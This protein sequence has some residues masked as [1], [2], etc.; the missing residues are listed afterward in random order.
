MKILPLLPGFGVLTGHGKPFRST[1][2]RLRPDRS[3]ELNMV[4]VQRPGSHMRYLN[5]D[6]AF[7]GL[8]TD[9]RSFGIQDKKGFAG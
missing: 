8:C 3:D 4:L 6:H 7:A 9:P 2:T 5:I 1:S